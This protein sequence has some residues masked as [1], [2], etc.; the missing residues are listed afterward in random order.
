MIDSLL[1]TFVHV[2]D[3]H[4]GDLDPSTGDAYLEES[5]RE[6][7]RRHGRFYGFFGHTRVALGHLAEFYARLREREGALLIHTG[8]L[9][10]H[11]GTAQLELA[12]RYF[13]ARLD[14]PRGPVGLDDPSALDLCV[15]GN[16]DHW[17]GN[18]W[19][20]GRAT[21][22]LRNSFPL[23]RAP[24]RVALPG[25]RSVLFA[26]IDTDADVWSWSPSR[27]LARGAF[28]SQLRRLARALPIPEAGEVRVL[29]LHHSPQFRGLDL[30]IQRRSRAALDRFIARHGFQVL[31]TGHIHTPEA[32]RRRVG[33][34]EVL[35]ARAGTTHLRD[36]LPAD[37]I[38]EGTG[39]LDPLPRNSL[40]VHRIR[41][42]SGGGIQWHTSM[43]VRTP[44]GF[45]EKRDGASVLGLRD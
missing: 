12:R 15:P 40:L 6:R 20:L 11:G 22:G 42:L 25:G 23:L 30:G 18:G 28:R 9:T 34:G 43:Y 19:V 1:A 36:Y 14:T 37:W 4:M 10:R 5:V 26:G 44:Q 45:V 32:T 29:L 35:E 21:P 8:D 13:T 16:H 17:P 3:T 38:A 31:L 24:R 33:G 41:G 7:W 27:A 2:S 39:P